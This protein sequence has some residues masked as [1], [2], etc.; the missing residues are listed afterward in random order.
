MPQ[1]AAYLKV[2][3]AKLVCETHSSGHKLELLK[4]D[5]KHGLLDVSHTNA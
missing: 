4:A 1:D 2:M 3:D 5:L